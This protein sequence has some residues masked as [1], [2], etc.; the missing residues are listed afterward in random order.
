MDDRNSKPKA[1]A[2]DIRSILGAMSDT[3][4][5]AILAI[6]P[7]VKELEEAAAWAGGESDVMGRMR[8]PASGPVAAICDI[9]AAVEEPFEETR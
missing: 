7:T 4:Y 2:S 6:G 3:R 1:T 9:I 8:R 5:A